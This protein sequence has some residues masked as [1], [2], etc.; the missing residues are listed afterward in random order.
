LFSI[1]V[2]A[3]ML[4]IYIPGCSGNTSGLIGF[5][6]L[7][8]NEGKYDGRSVTVEGFYFIGF[9]INAFSVGLKH[10]AG[11]YTSMPVPPNIWLAGAFPASS[12]L[13]NSAISVPIATG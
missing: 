5:E 6:E 8:S 13:V 10:R 11:A 9:E 2:A 1:L 4:A 3:M 7:I 12:K